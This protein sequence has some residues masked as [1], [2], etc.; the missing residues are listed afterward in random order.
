[1]KRAC[2]LLVLLGVAACATAPRPV[3]RSATRAARPTVALQSCVGAGETLLFTT[4]AKGQTVAR[5]LKDGAVVWTV[6]GKGKI[7]HCDDKLVVT[8]H[9]TE[10]GLTLHALG[11]GDGKELW[12]RSRKLP[13][14]VSDSNLSV[15]AWNDDAGLGVSWS[16]LTYWKGGYP[17]SEEEERAAHKEARGAFLIKPDGAVREL[18]GAPTYKAREL[19]AAIKAAFPGKQGYL[20][21]DGAHARFEVERR[22][23]LVHLTGRKRRSLPVAF[24]SAGAAIFVT[25]DGRAIL[26]GGSSERDKEGH[27]QAVRTARCWDAGGREVWSVEL[28]RER[29]PE[30]VP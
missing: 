25:R 28:S 4:D 22:T 1:M 27:E 17:P 23:E 2:L 15:E 18:S 30:P 14:W 6:A 19:P 24:G 26:V 8:A 7:A 21:W 9:I 3:P 11:V 13:D 10:K 29:V 5:A 16:A 12:I 20:T